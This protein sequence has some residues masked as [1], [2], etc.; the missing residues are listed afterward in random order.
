MDYVI[1]QISFVG[2]KKWVPLEIEV[3]VQSKPLRSKSFSN[4][5]DGHGHGHGHRDGPRDRERDRDRGSRKGERGG[6]DYE[7]YSDEGTSK[8][9]NAAGANEH[10]NSNFDNQNGRRR[11]RGR[12]PRPGRGPNGPGGSAG[13]A[14]AN[15]VPMRSRSSAEQKDFHDEYPRVIEPISVL[16]KIFGSF[17]SN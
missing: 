1:I 8:G 6:H 7:N 10:G 4:A 17:L 5:R 15:G 9:R 3:P 2:H 12:G 16:F 14:R 13:G 11:G